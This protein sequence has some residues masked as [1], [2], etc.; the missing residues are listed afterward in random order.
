[1]NELGFL[2]RQ[3]LPLTMDD[4]DSNDEEV[5]DVGGNSMLMY[6]CFISLFIF[7]VYVYLLALPIDERRSI[8]LPKRML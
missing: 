8:K 5:D 7:F 2:K 4:A 3:Q 1:M 6:L